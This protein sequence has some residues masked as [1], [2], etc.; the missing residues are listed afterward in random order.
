MPRTGLVVCILLLLFC[1]G[2]FV[3]K[4]E[5]LEL[6]K[7]YSGVYVIKKKIDVGNNET[8]SE[9]SRVRLYFRSDS[10]AIKV[11]AYPHNQSREMAV[12]KN[13]LLLFEEDFPDEKYDRS[14][15]E[16]KL[17]ELIDRAS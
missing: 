11:Y 9:G 2:R 15:F 16:Q 4:E 7:K 13:I 1:S 17:G 10:E 3:K 6:E 5:L 12:G 14:Y 8:L